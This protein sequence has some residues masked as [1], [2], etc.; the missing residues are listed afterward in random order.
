[1]CEVYDFPQKD[2]MDAMKTAISIF[3]DTRNGPTRNVMQGVLKFILD[4][5][6]ID[7]IKFV[8][9][10]IERGKQGGVRIIP[11]KMAHGRECP[12][13]G[14]VIYKRPENGGKVVFLSILQG[15]D[16]DLATYGC[17]G[18]KCVF[19]KWEEIK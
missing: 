1:M 3:L 8:D 15:D 14:E 17:G 7:Q 19:G 12:G 9:Y 18:C 11:R 16:G 2:D 10:I 4:K 13:C 6:K 5:Y